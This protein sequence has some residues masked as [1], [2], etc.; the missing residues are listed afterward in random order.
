[1]IHSSKVERFDSNQRPKSD[2]RK[3]R[4]GSSQSQ[5][6]EAARKAKTKMAV[7]KQS[8]HKGWMKHMDTRITT[9]IF[10]GMFVD[11]CWIVFLPL[12]FFGVFSILLCVVFIQEKFV[13][14]DFGIRSRLS[15]RTAVAMRCASSFQ[16]FS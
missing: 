12:L 9:I 3:L 4:A 10:F 11:C 7:E 15:L 14:G 2:A 16:F 13:R 6:Q 8:N 1:M 5:S